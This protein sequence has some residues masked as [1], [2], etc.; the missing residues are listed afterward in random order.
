[1]TVQI[2]LYD[3]AKAQIL[4]ASLQDQD[5]EPTLPG[6]RYWITLGLV[7]CL[8]GKWIALVGDLSATAKPK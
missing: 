6:F 5:D 3:D 7:L 2:C 8:F 4:H 1:M